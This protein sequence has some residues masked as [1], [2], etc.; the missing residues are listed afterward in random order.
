MP[1]DCKYIMAE[2][3]SFVV[4]SAGISHDRIYFDKKFSTAGRCKIVDGQIVCYGES[5]SLGLKADPADAE[6]IGLHLGIKEKK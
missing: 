1:S 5:Y 3:T 4:F 2:D 6:I